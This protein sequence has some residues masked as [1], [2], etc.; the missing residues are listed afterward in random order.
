LL[1]STGEETKKKAIS[2]LETEHGAAIRISDKT[3]NKL[4]SQMT[5]LLNSVS[6]EKDNWQEKL[7]D[8]HQELQSAVI[9]PTARRRR[10]G[11]L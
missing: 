1:L 8:L 9:E 5:D 2:K 4:K 7:T 3:F 10:D 6:V 11:M